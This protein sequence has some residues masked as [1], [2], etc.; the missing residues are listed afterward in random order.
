MKPQGPLMFVAFF[1]L[2]RVFKCP[3]C[4]PPWYGRFA[5]A[6]YKTMGWDVPLELRGW[7]VQDNE[8]ASGSTS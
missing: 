2:A 3:C 5:V 4:G 6:T 7:D 8:A 1:L